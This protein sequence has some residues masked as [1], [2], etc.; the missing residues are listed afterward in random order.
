MGYQLFRVGSV[1]HYRFQISGV[2]VQRSTREKVK[3]KADAVAARAYSRTR[4]WARGDEPVPTLRELVVQWVAIHAPTASPAHIK[5]VE[6][7]GRLHLY[8]LGD[9]LLDEIT[10]EQVE[11]A[12]IQ[13][14]ETHAPA[15]AN[16]WLKMLKTVCNWAVRRKVMPAIPW[17]VKL[18]KVQKRPRT[19]LPVRLMAAWLSNIDAG[20]R[21][22]VGVSIAV[23]MMI[24]IGL[25]ESET[26]TAR[27]EWIDWDRGV[28]T[29]GRTKGREAAP[30]PLPNWLVE[31]LSPL[32][33]SAG[34][35]VE[36]KHRRPFGPG[37]ARRA[38]EAANSACEIDGLTPHRLRGTFAT[39]LSEEGV[40]VQTIQRVLRHKDVRTTMHYLEENL[41]TAARAQQRIAS[42]A[43]LDSQASTK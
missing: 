39:L 19:M 38:I 25:R 13:H 40:P 43:G 10:T 17:S 20:N 42:L 29:P 2:R 1:W 3:H 32:R 27:W 24:G 34:P 41:D 30:V 5:N 22:E 23:R 15:S 36:A 28:Y 14:L 9:A 8:D 18:L 33:R 4:L 37:F 21:G 16:H 7:F 31:Y 6:T 35:I 26:L 11:L 12:R